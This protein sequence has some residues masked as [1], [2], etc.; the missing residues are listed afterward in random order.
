MTA[1]MTDRTTASPAGIGERPRRILIVQGLQRSGNHAV[2]GWLASLFPSHAFFNNNRHDLFADGAALDR[3]LEGRTEECLIFSFEDSGT[4][5]DPGVGLVDSVAPFPADR[6]PGVERHRLLLLRDPY[7]LW[8]SRV[9][10][11]QGR[12]EGLT[13]DPSWDNFRDNW[14]AIASRH[15]DAP[16]EVVLFNRWVSDAGYRR[17]LCARLGGTYSEASFGEVSGVGGGSSF[18]G[19]P[20]PT[21]GQMARDWRRYLSRGWRRRVMQRP[22]HYLRRLV[23][24]RS[25]G[26]RMKTDQR[27]K[28]LLGRPEARM[29]FADTALRAE[30]ARLFP[31]LAATIPTPEEQA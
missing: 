12:A 16:E 4:R 11:S 30:C 20:R 10:A 29:L 6:L 9:Q 25:T 15:R 17:A 8:A 3:L 23:K 26:T 21:Y 19:I 24:P 31:E 1:S 5:A 28:T 14:L 22:A 27:W 18:D 7:N 2:I 13:G